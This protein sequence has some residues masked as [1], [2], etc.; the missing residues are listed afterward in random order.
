MTRLLQSKE[1]RLTTEIINPVAKRHKSVTSPELEQ[2]LKAFVL[3]YQHQTTLSDALLIE[4][5]K[6]LASGFG[7]PPGKLQFSSGWL[8]KFKQ[9]NGIRQQKLQGEAASADQAAIVNALPLLHERCSRYPLNRIYNM[10]ETGLFYRFLFLY[11]FNNS[12]QCSPILII[13]V[14]VGTRQNAGNTASFGP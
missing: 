2:A 10:D 11:I 8:Q 1:E 5:A 9:R 14:Q 3:T 13:P 6:R 12:D 7:I 4:K